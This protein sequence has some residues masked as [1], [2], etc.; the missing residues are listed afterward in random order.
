MLRPASARVGAGNAVEGFQGI[1][2]DSGLPG[3]PDALP[4]PDNHIDGRA[5]KKPRERGQDLLQDL[6]AVQQARESAAFLV[7]VV[8][9]A[10]VDLH[11]RVRAL[12]L[13]G[14]LPDH[15][16]QDHVGPLQDGLRFLEGRDIL[17]DADDEGVPVRVDV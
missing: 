17:E 11:F 4:V 7:Q 2:R 13:G 1:G 8:Q 3:A 16:F 5:R 9:L 14:A 10:D 15:P 6:L 12:K